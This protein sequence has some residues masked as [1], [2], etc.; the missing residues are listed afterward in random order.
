MLGCCGKLNCITVAIL[1]IFKLTLKDVVE[2]IIWYLEFGF[3]N[4]ANMQF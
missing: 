1:L 2:I 4:F 3:L